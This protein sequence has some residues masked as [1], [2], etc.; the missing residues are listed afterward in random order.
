MFLCVFKSKMTGYSCVFKFLQCSMD[1]AYLYMLQLEEFSLSF[2]NCST[3]KT[4]VLLDIQE[5][6]ASWRY[7]I[8]GVC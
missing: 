8:P 6:G 2:V 3:K 4:V 5:Q 7:V 1:G